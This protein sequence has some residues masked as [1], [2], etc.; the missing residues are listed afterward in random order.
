MNGTCVH[1]WQMSHTVT[2]RLDDDLLA[3]LDAVAEATGVP[4]GTIIR[5]ELERARAAAPKPR[6][7]MRLAGSVRG[8][9]GLSQR[10]GFSK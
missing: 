4:R 8:P 10:R 2:I 1:F 6:A 9:K 5:D 3:W 7:Y